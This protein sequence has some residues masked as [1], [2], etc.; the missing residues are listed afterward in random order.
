[1]MQRWIWRWG[2]AI[3][4]L[5]L[6]SQASAQRTAPTA[7]WREDPFPSRYH[8][9]PAFDVLIRHATV[10]DGAG[11]RIDDGDVLVRGGRIVALGRGLAN[12]GLREIDAAGRWVTPGV[13][14]VHTH[15][16]SY[17]RPTTSVDVEANDISEM[18]SPNTA[19][20]WIQSAVNAQDPAFARALQHG[21]T[22]MQILPGSSPIFSGR[23]VIVKPIPAT[24][25]EE[26]KV[27][28]AP[29]GF[30]MACG[31][32][33]KEYGAEAGHE[34]PTSR[35]GVVAYMRTAFL[36]A[37]RYKAAWDRYRAGQGPL[38]ER[39]FKREALAGILA[40]DIRLNIHC[41]RA[42]DLAVMQA[43]AR[44]FGF[45]IAAF[46]HAT[47][48]YKV[49]ALL[50]ETGTCAAVW[51]DWW[52]FKMEAVDAIRANAPILDRAGVCVVMHSD[53]PFDGQ[54]L[55][56]AAA[57][58]ESGGR[59]IGITVPPERMIRWTTSNAARVLGLEKR[60]GTL[61]P[62]Y[63]A[64]VVLWSGNPFRVRSQP[65]LVLIGGGLVY[66]R[67]HPPARPPSDFLL[68]RR[69]GDAS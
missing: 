58:A 53:S 4:P 42:D 29:Q 13:I 8:A 25:V 5:L 66:D 31:E 50:R 20:T 60:I 46:H 67:A 45:R 55:N 69:A 16:G 21:V 39:D 19:D 47:D 7:P 33:P 10:L 22:T 26:M 62:G 38:P 37:R 30:K 15:V 44:E 54:R 32:N 3:L 24:T 12:P 59:R 68:G 1:M 36:D 9:P 6:T 61:A 23:S 35:Q 63:E 48:A 64:D 17:M 11:G 2:L 57:K 56:I 14:D 52:G 51:A 49:P 28:D 18:S 34:G 27:P 40:G 65:D 43:I 41:Y